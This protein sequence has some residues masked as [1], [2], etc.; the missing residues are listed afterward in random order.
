MHRIEMENSS[1][2]IANEIYVLFITRQN[3]SRSYHN[4]NETKFMP[5]DRIAREFVIYGLPFLCRIT[6]NP[7]YVHMALGFFDWC[8]R[9]N[10]CRENSENAKPRLTQ[11][12]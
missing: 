7:Q 5:R 11:Q 1:I 9:S 10:P 6:S 2:A 12:Q 3:I 4:F 8:F